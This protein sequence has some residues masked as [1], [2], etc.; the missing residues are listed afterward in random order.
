M[1]HSEACQLLIEQEIDN[2]LAAGKSFEEIGRDVSLLVGRLFE[3]S[4]KARTIAQKARR[5]EAANP[6]TN[7]TKL[8]ST[9]QNTS[10]IPDRKPSGKGTPGE[11]R[12]YQSLPAFTRQTGPGIEW[13]GWS[14]NPVTGCLHGCEYCY[15]RSMAVR[16]PE[17]FPKGFKPHFRKER[18]TAP[19]NTLVPANGNFADRLVFTVSMGD[20]FG[21]WVPQEW[22]DAVLDSIKN[23]P[24]WTFLLLTKNPKRLPAIDFSANCWVGATADTQVRATEAIKI[25]NAWENPPPV[26][27]LS[28]EPLLEFIDISK[29]QNIDWLI[30]GGQTGS[31]PKQ[32]EWVWVESLVEQARVANCKVYFKPNLTVRPKEYPIERLLL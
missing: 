24:Q 8:I 27:F 31:A 2:G 14:W 6:V 15:A 23:A 12:K 9:I 26:L 3:T 28:C 21:D 30:I 32:P 17:S 5:Q 19:Q 13:A 1:A 20:L 16:F 25:F 10:E 29:A 7:V 4:I 22:I 18:L 11:P